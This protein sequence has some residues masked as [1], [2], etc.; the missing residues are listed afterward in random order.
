MCFILESMVR[1]Y[2]G[3]SGTLKLTSIQ[4]QSGVKVYSLNKTFKELSGKL[5]GEE[6]KDTELALV[7]LL[8]LKNLDISPSYDYHIERGITDYL[9]FWTSRPENRDKRR[10]GNFIS[11]WVCE[12][13]LILSGAKKILLV[14][15]DEDFI[16]TKVLSDPHR[17][18]VLPNLRTYLERQEEYID[19]TKTWNKIDQEIIIKDAYDYIKNINKWLI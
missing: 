9:E 12:E 15:K 8:Q 11:P 17:R 19:F 18:A 6:P 16:K 4:K 3:I 13:S 1:I 2:Y 5:L 7:R 14:M 10:D